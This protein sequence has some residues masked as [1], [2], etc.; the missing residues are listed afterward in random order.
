MVWLRPY[1]R[2]LVEDTRTSEPCWIFARFSSFSIRRPSRRVGGSRVWGSW[3]NLLC[4]HLCIL[5]AIHGE[6]RERILLIL[7]AVS[8]PSVVICAIVDP[9]ANGVMISATLIMTD[10]RVGVQLDG[11]IPSIPTQ[12]PFQASFMRWGCRPACMDD[13]VVAQEASDVESSLRLDF[14]WLHNLRT[15]F[16]A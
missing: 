15:R 13:L 8:M 10:T 6:S 11:S 14:L 1:I 4:H 2:L 3:S 5:G 7:F 9:P 16:V 12:M